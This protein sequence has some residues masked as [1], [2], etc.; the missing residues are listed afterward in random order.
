MAAG[1]AAGAERAAR[2]VERQLGGHEE[3]AAALR[4][5]LGDRRD[6]YVLGRGVAACAAR[7]GALLFKEATDVHAEAMSG[8]TFRHGPLEQAGPGHGGR[9]RR[10][11]RPAPMGWMPISRWTSS[12]RARRWRGSAG[13]GAR[14]RAVTAIDVRGQ[15]GPLLAIPA[16][17]PLQLLAWRLA[18]E[19]GDPGSFRRAGKVTTKE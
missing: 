12:R 1:A 19:R 4:A 17:V 11:R 8:A 5:W 16:V 10:P 3:R 9:H 13:P 7:M 15:A 2:E 18:L 6:L 14:P